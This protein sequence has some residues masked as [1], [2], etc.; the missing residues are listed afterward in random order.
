L[1][2]NYWPIP[3]VLSVC[4]SFLTVG[5]SLDLSRLTGGGFSFGQQPKLFSFVPSLFASRVVLPNS[6]LLFL[7]LF[8]QIIHSLTNRGY[9]EV[10][11]AHTSLKLGSPSA[12]LLPIPTAHA[13]EAHQRPFGPSVRE[14]RLGPSARQVD[15]QSNY[16]RNQNP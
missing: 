6:A 9:G 11:R 2:F 13:G 10:I 7:N 8:A 4:L 3:L 14:L 16:G 5:F 15:G 1:L 12:T